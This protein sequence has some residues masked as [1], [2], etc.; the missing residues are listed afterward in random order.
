MRIRIKDDAAAILRATRKQN[1]AVQPDDHPCMADV[2]TLQGRTFDVDISMLFKDNFFV[3]SGQNFKS[4]KYDLSIDAEYVAEVIDDVRIGKTL[5]EFCGAIFDEKPSECEFCIDHQD[6]FE[7][8]APKDLRPMTV[9][10]L[11]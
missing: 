10:D 8:D 5:C 11:A 2:E 7:E 9:E 6:D 1:G 4:D 3:L